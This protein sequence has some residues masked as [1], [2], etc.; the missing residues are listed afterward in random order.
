MDDKTFK[1]EIEKVKNYVIKLAAVEGCDLNPNEEA[2]NAV[3]EG[4]ARNK[5]KY[6][7]MYCPC[8]IVTGNA[9]ED[10]PKIC[11]C[12]WHKE[13]LERDGHCHCMLLFKKK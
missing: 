6:G 4:L 5:I 13:E 12:K 8:R 10:R 3:V 9:E 11:P 1:Q 2:L 7:K